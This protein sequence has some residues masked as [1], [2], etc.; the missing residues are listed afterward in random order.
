M[1]GFMGFGLMGLG[2]EGFWDLDAG[3]GDLRFGVFGLNT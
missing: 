1:L 3:F 2:L